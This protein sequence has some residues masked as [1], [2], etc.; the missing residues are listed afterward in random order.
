MRDAAPACMRTAGI[1]AAILVSAL[2]LLAFYVIARAAGFHV[3]LWSSLAVT[4]VLT[5]VLNLV[6]GGLS[7]RRRRF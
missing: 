5:V 2:L 3:S 6:L 1:G 7:R 4:V